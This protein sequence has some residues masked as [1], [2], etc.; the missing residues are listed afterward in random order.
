LGLIQ[1][2]EDE[3]YQALLLNVAQQ[4]SEVREDD[5]ETSLTRAQFAALV[6]EAVQERM[7]DM[8]S[9]HAFVGVEGMHP[10]SISL[11][12]RNLTDEERRRGAN[13]KRPFK[14]VSEDWKS[15]GLGQ[16]SQEDMI[17]LTKEVDAEIASENALNYDQQAAPH[18]LDFI[19]PYDNA[20]Y[21]IAVPTVTYT[22]RS[23][24]CASEAG[25]TPK[26]EIRGA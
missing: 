21:W 10:K 17:V 12:T 23:R 1:Q 13:K 5:V 20:K 11:R 3:L 9:E 25:R 14:V 7:V 22:P 2:P 15:G 26:H 4:H 24:K 6:K 8:R 19:E 18:N 16:M